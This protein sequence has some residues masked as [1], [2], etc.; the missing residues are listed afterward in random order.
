MQVL[1]LLGSPRKGG[2][3]EVLMEAFLR[4]V[5]TAGGSVESVRLCDLKLSPCISC[6]GCTKTGHCVLQDDMTELYPKIDAAQRVI[7]A[8]P[9]YFYG[10]TAQA[11]AVVDRLQAMWSRNRLRRQKG[12]AWLDTQRKGVLLSVAATGGDRVFE[13][14]IL[15][16]K[17]ACDAMGIDYGGEFLVRNLEG[18]GAMAKAGD[19]LAEAE[20]AGRRL[21]EVGSVSG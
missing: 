8:S 14:A 10:I 2:N 7:L 18:R 3:S 17:Y 21:L 15:T 16:M 20:E 6:G 19:R 13:G 1:A 4:G 5:N 11:K 9:I 12:E